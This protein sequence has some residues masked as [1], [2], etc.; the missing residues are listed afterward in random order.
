MVVLQLYSFQND[1]FS[2]YS[3]FRSS[4]CLGFVLVRV[5]T[6]SH[7]NLSL[8]IYTDTKCFKQEFSPGMSFS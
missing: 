1:H 3:L 6:L 5:S 4:V 8:A 2:F 7:F